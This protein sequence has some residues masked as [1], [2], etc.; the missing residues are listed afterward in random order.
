MIDSRST[1]SLLAAAAIL[2]AVLGFSYDATFNGACEAVKDAHSAASN[3]GCL[4][5]RP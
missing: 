4:D 2:S 5:T 1:V 3:G